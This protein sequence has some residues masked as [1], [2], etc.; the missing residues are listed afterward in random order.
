MSPRDDRG[1]GTVLLLG[2]MAAVVLVAA[3]LGLLA[4]AQL[5]RGR[6]QSAADL[7]ALAGAAVLRHES[8]TGACALADEVARRNGA[9]L[10]DCT[11]EGDGVLGV[12]AVVHA[13]AGDATAAARAGPSSAR[14]VAG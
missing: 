6:A 1:S 8:A 7:A 2:L 4:S 13:A 10:V 5:A 11:D 3:L 14:A 12:R 9:R